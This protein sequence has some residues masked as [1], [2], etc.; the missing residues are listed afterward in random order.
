MGIEYML[1]VP[2]EYR[3]ATAAVLSRELRPLLARLDPRAGEDFPNVSV[4]VDDQGLLLCDNLTDA[5]VAAQVIRG[6]VDL[7]LSHSRSVSISEP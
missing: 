6:A 1:T 4:T 5:T 7:L 3:E 2:P